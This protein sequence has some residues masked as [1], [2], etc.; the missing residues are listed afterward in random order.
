MVTARAE[1][2]AAD[3]VLTEQRGVLEWIEKL[4]DVPMTVHSPKG[5]ITVAYVGRIES[6]GY[7]MDTRAPGLIFSEHPFYNFRNENDVTLLVG[8][9]LSFFVQERNDR[10]FDPDDTYLRAR[11]DQY[12]VRGTPFD[13][14]WISVQVGKFPT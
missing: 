2:E 12:F 10:G 6:E 1:S 13:E 8:E 11:F 5:W 4:G 3:D 9:H 14:P 7:I